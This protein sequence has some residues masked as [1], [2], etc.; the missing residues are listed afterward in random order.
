M[1]K[2]CTIV[3]GEARTFTVY[4]MLS[5]MTSHTE[6][7]R[8]GAETWGLGVRQMDEYIRRARVML[9]NDWDI[10]RKDLSAQLLTAYQEVLQEARQSRQLSNALGALAGI[11]RITRVD[12]STA[13]D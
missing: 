1:G 3:E 13:K 7:Y 10:E 5:T 11:A 8:H 4:K 9:M 2:K 12:P 6:I